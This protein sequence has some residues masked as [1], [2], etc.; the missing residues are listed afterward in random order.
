MRILIVSQYFWPENFR[1]NDLCEELVRRGHDVTV[2]TGLPNYPSGTVFD[3]YKQSPKIFRDYKGVKVIRVPVISRGYG[4]SLRLVLNYLSY[5]VLAGFYG[6]VK[7]RKKQFDVTFV[8]EPSPV[9]VCLPAIAIRKFKKIPVVFWVLD[10]WPETL[11]SVGA[12]KSEKL[13]NAVGKLVSYIYDR[14]DLVL[15]QSEAFYDGIARYCRDKSKIKY[16]PSW[17][18][19]IF[20][21]QQANTDNPL[22][23]EEA[24]FKVLF[25]GNVG[26]AQDFPS[27]LKAAEHLQSINSNAVFYIVGDGRVSAWLEREVFKRG[28]EKRVRL[29]GRQAL[30]AM[31]DFYAEADVLLVTLKK[32]PVFEKTIPGKIQTYLTAGK[33]ILTMMTGEGSEV[34]VRAECGLIADSGDYHKLCQNI[35]S[36]SAMSRE[37][38][39]ELGENARKY[40]DIHF[41]REK[42]INQLE[43]WFHS[44][45]YV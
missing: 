14:C 16:F 38:L 11:Q 25:A 45:S 39:L 44:V 10:L 29:L 36:L 24:T 32:S 22:S 34:I 21:R 43:E 20:S 12:V 42:L 26:E 31:P 4:S 8:Y 35:E 40:A 15:G 5:V 1:I 13:L 6:I 17:S 37:E 23:T 2:L 41:N 9:T 33:P 28:L 7:F 3:E 18:E 27:L 19:E 30:D